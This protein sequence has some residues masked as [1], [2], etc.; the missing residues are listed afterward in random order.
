MNNNVPLYL[1]PPWGS[2]LL[3]LARLSCAN[4]ETYTRNNHTTRPCCIG[5][6]GL[7]VQGRLF[8]ASKFKP[9]AVHAGL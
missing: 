8:K 1:S 7:H 4:A 9:V 3:R 2:I 6:L 5:R